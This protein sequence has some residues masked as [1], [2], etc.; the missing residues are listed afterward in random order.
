EGWLKRWRTAFDVEA[1]TDKFF[2]DY[3]KVFVAV[4]EE[5]KA[6]INDD[7]P[8]RLYTQRLFNRLMFIYFIQKKGWLSFNGD[9][10]YLRALF[11]AAEEKKENFLRDRLYWLFFSGMSNVAESR[12]VHSL[13]ILRERR[14]DV[15]YLNGGLFDMEDS[16]DER[17]GIKI[18]NDDFR[19]ILDLFERYNFTVEESTPID[20]QVAVDPE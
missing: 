8:A 20:V 10:K 11:N 13:E 5:V 17:D 4:E 2:K 15:P 3:H 9:E 14:G 18:S 12:E 6:T 19:K 7:E 16:W 1:V